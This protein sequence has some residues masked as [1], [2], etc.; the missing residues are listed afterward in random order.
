MPEIQLL[1]SRRYQVMITNSGGEFWQIGKTSPLPAGAKD[2]TKKTIMVF[3]CYI[4]DSVS[5]TYWSN[6]WKATAQELSNTLSQG[7]VE[8]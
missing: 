4:K 1:S 3:F 7:H 6:T 5:G 2:G 8:I